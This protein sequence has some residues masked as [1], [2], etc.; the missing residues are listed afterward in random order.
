MMVVGEEAIPKATST[1]SKSAGITPPPAARP[2]HVTFMVARTTVTTGA[3]GWGGGVVSEVIVTDVSEDHRPG[4]VKLPDSA[5]ARNFHVEP[6][7]KSMAIS[8][9]M[10]EVATVRQTSSGFSP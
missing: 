1:F 2:S 6:G 9:E 5:R 4:L 3:D 8:E 7:V 10:S